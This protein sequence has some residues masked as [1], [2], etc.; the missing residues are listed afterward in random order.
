MTNAL[1]DAD[2]THAWHWVRC[3]CGGALALATCTAVLFV[4]G[5]ALLSM[6]PDRY[7][8]LAFVVAVLAGGVLVLAAFVLPSRLSAL[9]LCT[10][11]ALL[12]AVG[13]LLLY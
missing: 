5:A 11:C 6:L 1:H 10:G 3:A 9:A 4:I 2:H 7:D 12:L 13:G 8:N